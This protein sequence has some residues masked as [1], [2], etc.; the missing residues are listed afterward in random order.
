ME[1]NNNKFKVIDTKNHA[2]YNFDNIIS[3]NDIDIDNILLDEKSYK[4]NLIYDFAYK[5]PYVAKPLRI[6]FD[7]VKGYIWKYDGTKYVA[8]FHSDEKYERNFDIIRY[9]IVSKNN[10]MDVDSHLCIM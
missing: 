7:K 8:L 10:I 4:N 3:I 1:S 6:I 5:T 9:L 2:F